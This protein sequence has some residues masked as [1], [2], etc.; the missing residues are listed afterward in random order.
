MS[1]LT[2]KAKLREA[3]EKAAVLRSFGLIPAVV[4]GPGL[5]ENI[6]LS[7]SDLD[8]S[9]FLKSG[10]KTKPFTIAVEGGK[11][12]K[13][14]LLQDVQ[15]DTLKGTV[16]SAD[17]YQF[18]ASKKVKVSLPIS[19]FGKAP[20]QDLGGVVVQSMNEIEVFCLPSNIPDKLEVDISVLIDFDST[21]YV[22]DLKLPEGVTV[23]ISGETP[24]VSVSEPQKE[25]SVVSQIPVEAGAVDSTQ[26][27]QSSG[28]KKD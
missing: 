16:L 18:D 26:A 20:A 13:N 24:V 11:E 5:E 7:V 28:A 17:F 19:I 21:I 22:K 25:E 3:K 6:L 9:L 8:F 12:I 4:Y 14:V 15:K 23:S 1:N 10:H 2:L 27:P